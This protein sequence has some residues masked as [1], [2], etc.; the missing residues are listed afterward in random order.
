MSIPLK[1][2]QR[3]MNSRVFPRSEYLHLERDVGSP[4][5][6]MIKLGERS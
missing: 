1:H 4:R 2:P 5:T 3:E 6:F